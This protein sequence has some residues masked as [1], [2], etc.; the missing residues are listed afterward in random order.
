MGPQMAH[1]FSYIKRIK[2]SS[3]AVSY[4]CLQVVQIRP[5]WASAHIISFLEHKNHRLLF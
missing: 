3:K 4:L 5:S 1:S 2:T